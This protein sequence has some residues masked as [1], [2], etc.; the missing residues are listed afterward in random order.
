[1]IMKASENEEIYVYATKQ[2]KI[3]LVNLVSKVLRKKLCY[4]TIRINLSISRSLLETAVYLEC[5]PD[6]N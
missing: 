4:Q 5:L 6:N 3:L 2:Q 1:M